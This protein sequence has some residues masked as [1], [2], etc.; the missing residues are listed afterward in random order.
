MAQATSQEEMNVSNATLKS[1]LERATV[2]VKSVDMI[3][4][5]ALIKFDFVI[6]DDSSLSLL[7]CDLLR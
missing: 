6:K 7:D 2:V 5:T 4:E 1:R 3:E